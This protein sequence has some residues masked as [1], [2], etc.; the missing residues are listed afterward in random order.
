MEEVKTKRR[1]ERS[2]RIRNSSCEVCQKVSKIAFETGMRLREEKG[3]KLTE[4][5]VIEEMESM[6]DES[7]DKTMWAVQN[8]LK[9]ISE[10]I[11]LK[12]MGEDAIRRRNDV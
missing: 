5:D 6:C 10:T 9:V 12:Y 3:E 7:D 8:D 4:V 1:F 2:N 11:V